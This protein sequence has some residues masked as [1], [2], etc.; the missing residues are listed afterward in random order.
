E[1]T[2]EFVRTPHVENKRGVI[3]LKPRCERRWLNPRRGHRRVAKPARQQL[4]GAILPCSQKRELHPLLF[5]GQVRCRRTLLARL[6]CSALISRSALALL[7]WR[8]FLI[9][10]FL[11]DRPR[12]R[13][14]PPRVETA[15]AIDCRGNVRLRRNLSR[16]P[17]R[18]VREGLALAPHDRR[19]PTERWL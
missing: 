16:T 2:S 11:R 15:G 14:W 18:P 17:S 5:R 12:D 1:R 13:Q 7:G 4:H 6:R 9:A 8:L 10:P 3:L 19:Q